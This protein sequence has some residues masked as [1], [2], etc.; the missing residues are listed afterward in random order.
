VTAS[1]ALTN[2]A[3]ILHADQFDPNTANNTASVTQTP[4]QAD[5]VLIKVV[6]PT[7]QLEGFTVT[8]TF[9]LTNNGPTTATN[10]TVTDPFP[11]SL[12]L[13]GPNTPSQGTFDAASGVWSVGSLADGA[14]ATL[15]VTAQ[16]DVLG[17]ITNTATASAAQFDPDL[18]NHTSS[19]SLTGQ[20]PPDQISKR[21]F[22]SGGAFADPAAAPVA[23][24]ADPPA[25]TSAQALPVALGSSMLVAPS[26]T[27][28]AAGPAT[29]TNPDSPMPAVAAPAAS[30]QTSRPDLLSGGGGDSPIVQSDPPTGGPFL[31]AWEDRPSDVLTTSE[32]ETYS[33]SGD[34]SDLD[35]C[36]TDWGRVAETEAVRPATWFRDDLPVGLDALAV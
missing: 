17:P 23:T 20:M 13:V 16:V 34:Y 25:A 8:Y 21:F 24:A 7:L 12:T 6:N 1:G 15:T 18:S 33:G 2:T 4:Q 29:P 11:S 35:C 22:L 28:T 27:A 9:F 26:P 30:F 10:V 32:S 14:S 5:L 31:T 19:A 3:A 36:L